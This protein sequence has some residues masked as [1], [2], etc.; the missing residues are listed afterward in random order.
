MTSFTP[1]R[2]QEVLRD[3]LLTILIRLI[4][5][6]LVALNSLEDIMRNMALEALGSVAL[7]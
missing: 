6:V 7:A 1:N 3:I 5:I 2:L 4:V